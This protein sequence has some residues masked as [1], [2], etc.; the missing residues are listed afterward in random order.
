MRKR[1]YRY[2]NVAILT[3]LLDG[4]NKITEYITECL[5]TENSCPILEDIK[6]FHEISNIPSGVPSQIY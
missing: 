5:E 6:P 2:K 1:I 3:N 4:F